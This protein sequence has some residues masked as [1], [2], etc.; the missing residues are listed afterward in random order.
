MSLSATYV[1]SVASLDPAVE[2]AGLLLAGD[3]SDW[4]LE[5]VGDKMSPY[6]LYAAVAKFRVKCVAGGDVPVEHYQEYKS[7]TAELRGL[8]WLAPGHQGERRQT[9]E[10]DELSS[11]GRVPD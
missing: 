2:G 5:K 11:G 1:P 6:A 8:E 3:A 4:R 7:I 10:R 9:Q